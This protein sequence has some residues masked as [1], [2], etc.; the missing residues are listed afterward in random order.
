MITIHFT[1]PGYKFQGVYSIP[2]HMLGQTLAF[3]AERGYVVEGR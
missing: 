1:Q 2:Q 3:L